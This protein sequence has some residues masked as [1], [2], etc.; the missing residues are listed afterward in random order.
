ML[1]FVPLAIIACHLLG[2]PVTAY[3]IPGLSSSSSEDLANAAGPAQHSFPALH[4]SVKPRPG[5]KPALFYVDRCQR[6]IRRTLG[7]VPQWDKEVFE[8]SAIRRRE[9]RQRYCKP[10]HVGVR[11]DIER[12]WK[13]IIHSIHARIRHEMMQNIETAERDLETLH[14]M[15]F[16]QMHEARVA[17]EKLLPRLREEMKEMDDRMDVINRRPGL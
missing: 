17:R 3:A 14:G 7:A 4:G 5:L 8:A 13:D 10:R 2:S 9:I 1:P 6:A 15:G 12:N 11:A 16:D